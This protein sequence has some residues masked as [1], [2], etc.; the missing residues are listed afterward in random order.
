MALDKSFFDTLPK[1]KR[2]PKSKAD[3]AW[4][5]YD[6]KLVKEKDE[7]PERYTLKKVDEVFTEFEPA[8]LSITTP[9]PGKVD[10]FMKLLQEKLDDQL[11]TP[12]VNKTIER[13]F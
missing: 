9:T 11:E 2:V 3:I 12:P 8:L 10:D 4:L 7:R 5:V 6:L 13:P 1:L